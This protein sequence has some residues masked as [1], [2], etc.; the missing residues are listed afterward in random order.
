MLDMPELK[1]TLLEL[2]LHEEKV[3][4]MTKRSNT[5]PS[6]GALVPGMGI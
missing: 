1:R 2:G 6:C 3:Y 5:L 4:T